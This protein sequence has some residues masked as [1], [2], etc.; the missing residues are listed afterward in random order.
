VPAGRECRNLARLSCG[1]T[2]PTFNHT[3]SPI[4][5]Y[6]GIDK[7]LSSAKFRRTVTLLGKIFAVV[8]LLAVLAVPASQALFE[9]A[10]H[11]CSAEVA[12]ESSSDSTD[13]PTTD[14]SGCAPHSHSFVALIDPPLALF[15]SSTLSSFFEFGVASPPETLREIDYP[16][17]LS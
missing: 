5:S 16:P 7:T 9:C 6:S 17:Q 1:R 14:H 15:V 8:L 2:S 3:L 13:V 12:D 11:D 10:H 4:P